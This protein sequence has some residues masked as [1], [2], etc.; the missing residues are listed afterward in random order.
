MNP[1]EDLI[2]VLV[3]SA[4]GEGRA[5]NWRVT[6]LQAFIQRAPGSA[7]WNRNGH[8]GAQ[9]INSPC[10]IAIVRNSRAVCFLTFFSPCFKIFHK[11]RKMSPLELCPKAPLSA[12]EWGPGSSWTVP[13]PWG[14]VLKTSAVEEKLPRYR[15]V[16][17]STLH[18][19]APLRAWPRRGASECVCLKGSQSKG[20]RE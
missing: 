7:S 17:S 19:C 20:G 8:W 13:E 18:L 15:T 10:C 14:V 6:V 5:A 4:G 2:V 11:Q 1:S 9:R 12:S 3:S 16:F